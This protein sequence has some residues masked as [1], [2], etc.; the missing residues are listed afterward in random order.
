MATDEGI[1]IVRDNGEG[2]GEG[3]G[4]DDSSSI[5]DDIGDLFN[6]LLGWLKHVGYV[7]LQWNL[8]PPSDPPYGSTRDLTKEEIEEDQK[9]LFQQ[10]IAV[11]DCF[12]EL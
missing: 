6:E 3:E 4:E 11:F 5:D 1:R 9:K 2:E 7:L 8:Y 10:Y 12:E